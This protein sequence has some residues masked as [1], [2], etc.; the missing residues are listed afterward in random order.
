MKWLNKSGLLIFTFVILFSSCR[1]DTVNPDYVGKWSAIEIFTEN[2]VSIQYKDIMTFS[3]GG[4]NDLGQLYDASTSKFI[5]YIELNGTISVSGTTMSVMITEIGFSSFD[6]ISGKPTGTIVSYKEGSSQFESLI[7]QSGQPKSFTSE[8]S[9]SGNEMT[10][11][12]DN[13]NDGDYTDLNE[14]IV[15]TKQ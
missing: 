7:T 10:I 6:M 2:G 8:Y 5:D 15:Y 3:T 11:K 14:T 12:T 13:N 9:V 1:K 4:F